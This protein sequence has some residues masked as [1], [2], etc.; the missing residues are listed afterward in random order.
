MAFFRRRTGRITILKIFNDKN[1]GFVSSKTKS[2]SEIL[3]SLFSPN[4]I[5]YE[6]KKLS[7]PEF[8]KQEKDKE[9]AEE[10]RL[11]DKYGYETQKDFE[12]DDLAKYKQVFG[13][14]SP[15]GIKL[16]PKAKIQQELKGRIEAAKFGKPYIPTGVK[17]A[18][19]YRTKG[20][21]K[22]KSRVI[23]PKLQESSSSSSSYYKSRFKGD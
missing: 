11:L 23:V 6:L 19:L 13:D 18:A 7:D 4:S 9:D 15:Y 12:Y 20:P 21:R 8:K 17:G 3:A 10:K 16:A 1:V 2:D 14:N 5:N 22:L